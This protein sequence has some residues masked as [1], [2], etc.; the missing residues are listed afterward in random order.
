MSS[1][2]A[3]GNQGQTEVAE[4]EVAA[5]AVVVVVDSEE[6]MMEDG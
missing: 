4:V 6:A 5:E 2:R 1:S 3:H